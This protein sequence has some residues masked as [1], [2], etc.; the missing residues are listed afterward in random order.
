[1]TED[2]SKEVTSTEE[3]AEMIQQQREQR[4]DQ[5]TFEWVETIREAGEAHRDVEDIKAVAAEIEE[6]KETTEEALTAY[7]LLFEKQPMWTG[8]KAI[9]PG[10]AYFSLDRE[11]EDGYDSEECGEPAE[12][13]LR[14]Y[15]GGLYME[16]DIADEPVGDPP[17]ASEPPN[18][19]IGEMF[20][21]TVI[22]TLANTSVINTDLI[23]TAV[24]Q[25]YLSVVQEQMEAVLALTQL[26]E[27]LISDQLAVL[28]GGFSEAYIEKSMSGIAAVLGASNLLSETNPPESVIA[29]IQQFEEPVLIPNESYWESNTHSTDSP[30]GP[31]PSSDEPTTPPSTDIGGLPDSSPVDGQAAALTID[32]TLPDAQKPTTD[33]PM[34]VP[35]LIV[36]TMLSSGD[37]YRWF[38]QLDKPYQNA[39][40]GVLIGIVALQI[41]PTAA[42]VLPSMAPA[43]R[44]RILSSEEQSDE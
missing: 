20:E 41:S 1:M 13:L 2:E 29:D 26:R 36:Q 44:K 28:A 4:I 31:P 22:P 38:K 39:V 43:V 21:D 7:R 16:E 30:D 5:V 23:A 14:D 24:T 32:A 3:F 17:E 19:D 15:V 6:N 34:E 12:K 9:E 11:L 40:V 27:E 35:G 37:A 42:S 25:P 10:R 8:S 33:V 18:I